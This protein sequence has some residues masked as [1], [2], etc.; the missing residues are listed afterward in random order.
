M[1]LKKDEPVK[2]DDFSPLSP[3]VKGYELR[4]DRAYLIVCDGKKFSMQAAQA[5]MRDARE[6]HPDLNVSI[7]A[8]VAPK[9]ITVMESKEA[10]DGSSDGSA[11]DTG[12]SAARDGGE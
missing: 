10:T 12:G 7:V 2:I 1:P 4:P 8:T 6:M 9:E 11:A 5:L 3:L